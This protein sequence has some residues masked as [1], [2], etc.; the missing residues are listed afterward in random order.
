MNV[1]EI[2]PKLRSL[3]NRRNIEGMARFGIRGKNI[4]GISKPKLDRL[5]R[6]I[7]K[8]HKLALKLWDTRVHEARILAVLIDQ[9]QRVTSAQMEKW[10]KGFD[11]WDIC[12]CCCCHLLIVRRGW[13]KKPCN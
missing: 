7:G 6:A 12:D 11:S 4:L 2:L 8:D 3:K 10:V 5:S 9:P 1:K 13:S